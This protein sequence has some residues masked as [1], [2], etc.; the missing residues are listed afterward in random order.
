VDACI[1][2][3]TAGRS[4]PDW[5]PPGLPARERLAW[6][7][8]RFDGVEVDS[9]FYGLP[10]RRTTE[11]WTATTPP[12]FSFDVKLHR[13]LSRHA[14][15][16]SSLPVDLR[17]DVR[18]GERGR[19]LLDEE[20]AR[21]MCT[22]TL[23]VVA[24]LRDADKLSSF[25]LQLTSAFKP[26]HHRLDELEPRCAR[27]PRS[28]WR[29][30]CVTATGW[31]RRSPRS[32]GSA[33]LEPPL[34]AWMPRRLNNP[35]GILGRACRAG[36]RH[37]RRRTARGSDVVVDVDARSGW[38]SRARELPISRTRAIAIRKLFASMLPHADALSPK[39]A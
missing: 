37:R 26:A 19:V 23:E 15:P 1:V 30:S 31:Q 12:G 38:C 10:A 14:A 5:Y 39:R 25:L 4:L 18:R 3:G 2:V 35:W 17:G 20:L 6:Y 24:P 27:S 8:Q 7:A 21:T 33:R 13:L 29:S 36:R 11:R 9:T 16:L 34:S 28:R 32:A 22:R